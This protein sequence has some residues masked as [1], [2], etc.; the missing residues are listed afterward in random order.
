M[1]NP[2]VSDQEQPQDRSKLDSLTIIGVVTVSMI[3]IGVAFFGSFHAISGVAEGKE[4]DHSWLPAVMIDAGLVAFI[5]LDLFMTKQAM[6]Q[7]LLKHA[8]RGFTALT[9][10]ANAIAGWPDAVA[11]LLHI[12]AAL[13]ILVITESARTYLLRKMKKQAGQEYDPIPIQRWF[14]S[15][16]PTFLLW[17]RML[18][19]GETSYE[20]ALDTDITRRDWIDQCKALGSGWKKQVPANLRRQLRQGV[21]LDSVG[22]RVAQI[23]GSTSDLAALEQGARQEPSPAQ[24]E[25][26]PAPAT[27]EQEGR[28][29]LP[30]K[31]S[32]DPD[33]ERDPD[34]T[35]PGPQGGGE[36]D[37]AP[38]PAPAPAPEPQPQ[39]GQER[40]LEPALAPLMRSAFVALQEPAEPTTKREQMRRM[41]F[42]HGG[43]TK[44]VAALLRSR[45]GASK[46]PGDLYK[47]RS[48]WVRDVVLAL[49]A[50]ELELASPEE[51]LTALPDHITKRPEA[52]QALQEWQA[53]RANVVTLRAGQ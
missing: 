8:V 30:P 33:P 16:I 42:E 44:A 51:L 20:K 47:Y 48:E 37:P 29:S 35:P 46:A 10:I 41:L 25:A 49:L 7:K 38:I 14:L 1:T 19:W 43:D 45:T 4:M 40:T 39:E 3:M 27:P 6:P 50:E 12:P 52:T 32:A 23:I 11:V 21:R 31:D 17:R 36:P 18:L 15:P 34:P 2:P 26:L 9:V 53:G 28:A 22:P 13:G 5:L 24:R